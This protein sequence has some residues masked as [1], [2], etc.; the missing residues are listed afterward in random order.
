M[1]SFKREMERVTESVNSM[2]A[3]LVAIVQ[4]PLLVD[5]GNAVAFQ[6]RTL[7]PQMFEAFKTV[8]SFNAHRHARR[9]WEE[10]EKCWIPV[11][12]GDAIYS[13]Q[14]LTRSGGM[15]NY[16]HPAPVPLAA[17][18][19]TTEEERELRDWVQRTDDVARR[20]NA[21]THTMG[22]LAD[23][24]NTVG[25]L[26][27]IA[28][29]MI[30]YLPPALQA[31]ANE[32]VRRSRLTQDAMTYPRAKIRVLCDTL[33]MAALISDAMVDAAKQAGSNRGYPAYMSFT[34]EGWHYRPWAMRV[35]WDTAEAGA[36]ENPWQFEP[37][38]SYEG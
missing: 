25:Q 30:R 17:I 19:L 29:D 1:R 31:S 38:T 10:R 20:V 16:I 4:P 33:A 11:D 7:P 27:R 3:K 35:T 14:V 23:I 26:K 15:L 37:N 34:A 12:F 8:E 22:N 13:I 28:P 24:T 2:L 5:C 32:M 18:G 21:A 9:L 6:Q 36:D